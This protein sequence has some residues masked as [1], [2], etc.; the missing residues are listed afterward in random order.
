MKLVGRI[1]ASFFLILAG[2]LATVL[3]FIEIRS[4]VAGDFLLMNTPALSFVGY[5]FRFLYFVALCSFNVT[6]FINIILKKKLSFIFLFFIPFILL[7]SAFSIFFYSTYIYFLV[8][9]I[10]LVPALVLVGKKFIV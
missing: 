4:L 2:L 10:A 6:L 9:F 5:L 3:A 1:F 8:I 7:S